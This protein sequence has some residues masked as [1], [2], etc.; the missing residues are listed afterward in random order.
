MRK[1][2]YL[3]RH[4]QTHFNKERRW[5][6][7]KHDSELTEEGIKQAQEL[8]ENLIGKGLQIVFTSPFKR[9]LK[10]AEVVADKLDIPI[11]IRD[12]LKEGCFGVAEGKTVDEIK[13][14]FSE[15]CKD[16]YG[17]YE[18]SFDV[19]F[20]GGETK[21]Q[22]G[23]RVICELKKALNETYDV[24]GFCSHSGS[25]RYAVFNLLG[26][27]IEILQNAAYLHIIYEDGEWSLV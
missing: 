3:F 4:G 17:T 27:N 9:A 12:G 10:T 6:G 22:I 11:C 2:F 24:I 21:K 8:A 20:E 14:E 16:W 25:I 1:D 5:Q 23:E 7:Q 18:S 15:V 13:M 26:Q 19:C